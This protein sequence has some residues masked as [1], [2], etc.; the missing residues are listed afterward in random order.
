MHSL[1]G[2]RHTLAASDEASGQRSRAA[3]DFDAI[4]S[5][6]EELRKDQPQKEAIKADEEFCAWCGANW[7]RYFRHSIPAAVVNKIG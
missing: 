4:R 6:M 3:D 5:R 7:F 1:P 2:W